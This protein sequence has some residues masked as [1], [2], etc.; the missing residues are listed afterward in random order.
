MIASMFV[1]GVQAA[2]L[3]ARD[4]CPEF[5]TNAAT[6]RPVTTSPKREREPRMCWPSFAVDAPMDRTYPAR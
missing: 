2:A 4:A 5:G 3:R 6:I 1:T